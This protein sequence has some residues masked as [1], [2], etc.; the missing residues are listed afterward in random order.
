MSLPV[1]VGYDSREDIAYQVCK[2]SIIRREPGA[3]VKPLKQKD[4]RDSELYTRDVDKLASTEFTFTRFF[5]PH[6]Q[7]YQGWAVF[8]DC[9][10]V[11]TV[12]TTDL[13]QYCDPS[14]AVVVVQHDYTPAEGMKMDGK[15][16]HIYPRKNWSSMILWNCAHPKNKVL[17]P[18]LLNRESGAFLHRF[19]WL[20]DEDIGSLPHHY[21][22]LVGWYKEPKDGKPKIY[23]WTEG[24]PW[25]V[26]NYFD[27]EYADVWKKETINL[28]SK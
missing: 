26:D 12:P 14:K 20:D 16:Q 22:W 27:C 1:Y 25:F 28:F 9:D 8:C 7:N 21:N 13:K 15:Q 4:M 2:H 18:E 3:T 23:H 10:F 19:Q 17:T 24:G 6:L 5:I 11:W